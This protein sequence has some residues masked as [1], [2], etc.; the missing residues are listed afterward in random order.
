MALF[1]DQQWFNERLAAAGL[2]RAEL[3]RALGLD[4]AQLEELWK[5]Q[6][7]V[8]ER[9]VRMLALLLRASEKEIRTRAGVQG[10]PVGAERR[11]EARRAT[12]AP[13][14]EAVE[15]RLDRIEARLAAIEKLLRA[16]KGDKDA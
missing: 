5:D 6:R 4:E 3:A 16:G 10:P 12:A 14:G 2:S 13:E 15:A 9:D 7:E 8:R 1:F 11:A